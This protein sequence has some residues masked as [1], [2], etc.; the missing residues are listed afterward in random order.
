MRRTKAVNYI[1]CCT[2]N[3]SAAELL[4]AQS[5]EAYPEGGHKQAPRLGTACD[6]SH[7]LD[8]LLVRFTLYMLLCRLKLTNDEMFSYTNNGNTEY[9][10]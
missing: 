6:T 9:N 1:I 10:K 3:L 8:P 2:G 4:D 5:K 7:T